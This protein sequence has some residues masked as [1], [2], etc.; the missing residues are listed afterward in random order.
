MKGV[1]VLFSKFCDIGL[2]SPELRISATSSSS[3][4]RE[5]E[6]TKTPLA[7]VVVSRLTMQIDLNRNW[8]TEQQKLCS[9]TMVLQQHRNNRD[10]NNRSSLLSKQ[11]PYRGPRHLSSFAF[12]YIVQCS[13]VDNL[14]LQFRYYFHHTTTYQNTS[15]FFITN[16]PHYRAL[17]K[18]SFRVLLEAIRRV[19]I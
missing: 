13:R 7:H 17:L 5:H 12:M 14:S 8:L 11:S 9:R 15:S 1:K 16:S 3:N 4:R 10:T 19:K 18:Q 2:R 6:K